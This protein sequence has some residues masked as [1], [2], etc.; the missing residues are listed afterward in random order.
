VGFRPMTL[1]PTRGVL[2]S[3]KRQCARPTTGFSIT[4]SPYRRPTL[5]SMPVDAKAGC[6]YPK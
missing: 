4:L 1:S 5:D 3:M 6:L 2:R